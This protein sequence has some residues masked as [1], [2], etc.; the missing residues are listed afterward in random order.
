MEVEDVCYDT[1]NDYEMED[2]LSEDEKVED[3]YTLEE[4]EYD[5][6]THVKTAIDNFCQ[7][8]ALPLGE[9]ITY[10]N[11]KNMLFGN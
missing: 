8:N 5:L 3:E 6:V 1:S 2:V 11:M 7:E 4:I 10:E 9:F